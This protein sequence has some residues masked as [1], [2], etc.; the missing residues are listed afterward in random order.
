MIKY[1]AISNGNINQC[2]VFSLKMET[3][4]TTSTYESTYEYIYK[5]VFAVCSNMYVQKWCI[6]KYINICTYTFVAYIVK[7]RTQRK[8]SMLV[9]V[10]QYM[11]D[12]IAVIVI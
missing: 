12:F 2:L 11:F 9:K 3:N 7:K 5:F 8:Y 1:K 10:L 6:Y 4:G